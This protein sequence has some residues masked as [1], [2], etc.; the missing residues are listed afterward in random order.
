M[1]TG[2]LLLLLPLA[3]LSLWLFWRE[4]RRR[5]LLHRGTLLREQGFQREERDHEKV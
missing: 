5:G 3:Y 2:I 4:K 1:N